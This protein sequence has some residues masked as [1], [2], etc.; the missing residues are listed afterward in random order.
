MERRVYESAQGPIYTFST[1]DYTSMAEYLTCDAFY[2]ADATPN[3]LNDLFV[4]A[5]AAGWTFTK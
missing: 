1:A 5:I 4:A 3:E 2:A